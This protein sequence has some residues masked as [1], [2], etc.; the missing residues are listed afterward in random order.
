MGGKIPQPIRL[1][2]I[3]KWL[4]GYSR[5]G[6]A[7]EEG[8]GN[9]TVS[10]ILEQ[11][12]KED[13]DF[14]LLRAVALLLK[15][16]KI[17][18]EDFAPLF[19]LKSMLEEKEVQLEM[20]QNDNLFSEYRKFEAIIIAFEV[21]CFKNGVT[22][23]QFFANVADLYSLYERYGASE[24][25]LFDYVVRLKHDIEW[26]QKEIQRLR[27]E[28]KDEVERKG[29]TMNLLQDYKANSPLF[30]FTKRELEKVSKERDVCQKQL[31]NVREQFERIV[32][33]KKEDEYGWSVYSE[34][35]DEAEA[36]LRTEMDVNE[37]DYYLSRLSKIGLRKI[38]FDFSHY[39]SEY[40]A[41]IRHMIDIYDKLHS[42][43]PRK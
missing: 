26:Q 18:I 33:D 24:K 36:R 30:E 41:P 20:P 19:R 7:K 23:D 34:G 16:R 32:W 43:S 4:R 17:R 42:P 9:G 8:I 12:R 25:G 29:A 5:D 27:L 28:T 1:A 22:M 37:M 6:I 11:C 31:E 35:E 2:V 39:P 10:A 38:I 14:D 13:I 40:T 15:D 3:R 21:L